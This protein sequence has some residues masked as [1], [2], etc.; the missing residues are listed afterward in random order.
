MVTYDAPHA[1]P[2][3]RPG[4]GNGEVGEGNEVKGREGG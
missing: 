1:D 3:S 2:P 4:N